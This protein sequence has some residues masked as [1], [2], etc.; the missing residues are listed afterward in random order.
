MIIKSLA[1]QH[2]RNHTSTSFKLSPNV[3][4][5]FG[6]NASGKTTIIEGLSLLSTGNSFRATKIEELL[7]FGAELGRIKAVLGN[8]LDTESGTDELEVIITPGEVQGRK[9]ARRLFS[10]NGV[11]RRKKDA[12]GKFYAVVF[13]PEDMR[14][15]EGSPARR[16]GFIDS[17]LSTL[18]QDYEYSLSQYEKTLKRRNKL[19]SQIRDG[20]QSASSL[21]FWNVSLVKHGEVLQ[22]QRRNFLSEFVGASAPLPFLIQYQPSII[23]EERIKQYASREIAAGHTLIGPH[24]DD[25]SVLLPMKG[26]DRNIAAFGSRG[27]QRLAVLWL[28]ISELNYAHKIM[29]QAPILLLDDILSEL[30]SDSRQLALEI[31]NQQQTM[32]TTASEQTARK[33]APLFSQV[34]LLELNEGDLIE[35]QS[36][37]TE[38]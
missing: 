5:L 33:I 6:D 14:L 20:E 7:Q 10:V 17:A 16:R 30:D 29:Q 15:I 22:K 3:T 38:S 21:N 24:K 31:A 37:V 8:L 35:L 25:F 12:V 9:T 11:R 18:H 4:V 1:L 32:I 28:K 13:R 36:I 27:Q 2:I 34:L 19:L 26:E 23:S